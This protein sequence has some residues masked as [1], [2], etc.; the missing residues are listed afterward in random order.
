M[1]APSS[2]AGRC[3]RAALITLLA[4]PLLG[5]TC[6]EDFL[7][8]LFGPPTDLITCMGTGAGDGF[9]ARAFYVE[10]YPG[11]SLTRV[12]LQLS[13]R[14]DGS[15]TLEL[16]AR[17][18]TYDGRLLGTSRTTVTIG[19]APVVFDFPAV[20][21]PTGSTV[22]FDGEIVSGPGSFVFMQT[23]TTCPEVTET[24]GSTPPLDTPRFGGRGMAVTITGHPP[25]GTP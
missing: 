22:T 12:V 10:E 16:Q 17:L 13:A 25:A 14:T 20:A 2:L 4:I 5:L 23:S 8:E 24:N 15:Y 3:L 6:D 21:V 9:D 7:T 11:S 1:P 18:D 19:D